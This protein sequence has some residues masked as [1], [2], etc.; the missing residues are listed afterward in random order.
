MRSL[1]QT[2]EMGGTHWFEGSRLKHL[3]LLEMQVPVHAEVDELLVHEREDDCVVL[4]H[5]CRRRYGG[6]R[7]RKR[8]PLRRQLG[9][10][11]RTACTLL[12]RRVPTAYGTMHSALWAYEA[13][14]STLGV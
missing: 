3:E 2:S 12:G 5:R 11:H 6:R 9:L 13:T 10:E 1:V 14:S 8:R 7:A 4:G